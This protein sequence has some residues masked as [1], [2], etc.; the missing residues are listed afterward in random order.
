MTTPS[1]RT[2]EIQAE[3]RALAA[4]LSRA[5]LAGEEAQGQAVNGLFRTAHS[6]KGVAGLLG[7]QDASR[8]AHA[9]EDVFDELRHCRARLV[10]GLRAALLDAVERCVLLLDGPD[11]AEAARLCTRLRTLL[12][13]AAVEEGGD[14]I[15]SLELPPVVA[16]AL[17]DYEKAR[18]RESLRLGRLVHR[19]TAGFGLD[20]FDTGLEEIQRRV[21]TSGELIATLPASTEAE[22]SFELVVATSHDAAALGGILAGLPLRI[23]PVARAP[24]SAPAA[25]AGDPEEGQEQRVRVSLA[26]LRSLEA[27]VRAVEAQLPPDPDPALLAAIRHLHR[28][29]WRI[30]HVPAAD[31]AAQVEQRIAAVA[32]AWGRQVAF[33]AE[34]AGVEID[35]ATAEAL[36]EPLLHLVRNAIDHG[37]EAPGERL[38]LG[39]PTIGTIRLS[40]REAE[41]RLVVRLADD[42]AGIDATRVAAAARTL[43]GVERVAAMDHEALL[44]LV[45]FPGVSTA[46]QGGRS[47]RGVGLDVVQTAVLRLGGTAHVASTPGEAT[48]FTLS[49]PVPA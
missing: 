39:K 27:S 1:A 10:P 26:A 20:D 22:I 48:A 13:E 8:V 35:V 7:A 21:S 34:G 19:V 25:V 36:A 5:L 47:G 28:E 46:G 41:G 18:L 17:T 9:I 43:L 2:S 6:L 16:E 40:F 4:A 38:R 11:G 49:L 45:F 24:R 37:I 14:A 30:G 33:R 12:A 3:A 29:T 23:E 32:T 15:D 31:L 42:G 44:Q